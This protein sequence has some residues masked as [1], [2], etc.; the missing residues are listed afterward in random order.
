MYVYTLKLH[1]YIGIWIA[2]EL[3]SAARYCLYD[4]NQLILIIMSHFLNY[5]CALAFA[6][7]LETLFS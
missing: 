1:L 5:H 3:C 4:V 2:V 6:G 7:L